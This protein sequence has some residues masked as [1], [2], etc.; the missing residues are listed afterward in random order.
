MVA[1]KD[2]ILNG[3]KLENA[4]I[5]EIRVAKEPRGRAPCKMG[6]DVL[7]FVNFRLWLKELLLELV[8]MAVA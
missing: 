8:V 1:E 5:A 6:L 2:W 7:L 4:A 3:K